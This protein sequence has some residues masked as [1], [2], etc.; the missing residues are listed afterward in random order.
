MSQKF[1]PHTGPGFKCRLG[2]VV[3]LKVTLAWTNRTAVRNASFASD[4]HHNGPE[5]LARAGR[6]LLLTVSSSRGKPLIEVIRTT[7]HKTSTS[8]SVSNEGIPRAVKHDTPLFTGFLSFPFL[9]GRA[10]SCRSVSIPAKSVCAPGLVCNPNT[11]TCVPGR[12]GEGKGKAVRPRQARG[13]MRDLS[14]PLPTHPSFPRAR[15]RAE[16]PSTPLLI[17]SPTTSA[18]PA[19]QVRFWPRP[20]VRPVGLGV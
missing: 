15:G 3:F 4:R 9:S 5:S 11:G 14:P 16:S 13:A 18:L 10:N 20:S 1:V 7:S 17:R 19:I 8:S 12:K 6:L 2:G